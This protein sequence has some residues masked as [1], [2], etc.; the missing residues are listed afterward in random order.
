[1][2]DHGRWRE[3]F[4][5]EMIGGAAPWCCFVSAP[6]PHDPFITGRRRSRSTTST[7]IAARTEHRPRTG[8]AARDLPQGARV[9]DGD[10]A[11]QK[12]EAAA[13]YYASIT[14]IDAQWGG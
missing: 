9:W 6:E 14:E 4:Q 10:D 8:R 13:C 1:M 12:P 3:E 2:G 11:R 5:S 7:R